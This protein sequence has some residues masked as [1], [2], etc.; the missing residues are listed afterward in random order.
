MDDEEQ[1]QLPPFPVSGRSQHFG[2]GM[3]SGS[4]V[5]PGLAEMAKKYKA[6]TPTS[7][8]PSG[9]SNGMS[10]GQYQ[11]TLGGL[12]GVQNGSAT[13]TYNVKKFYGSMS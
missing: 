7:Y 10:A 13:D 8:K 2:E 3:L 11:A 9:S 4:E 1:Q 5:S 6:E 12:F